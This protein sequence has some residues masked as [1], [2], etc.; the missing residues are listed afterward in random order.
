MNIQEVLESDYEQYPVLLIPSHSS[1]LTPDEE[2]EEKVR[3][4]EYKKEVIEIHNKNKEKVDFLLSLE[5]PSSSSSP[6][7]SS[8]RSLSSSYGKKERR[9]RSGARQRRERR[10]KEKDDEEIVRE[11]REK[12][13]LTFLKDINSE[14]RKQNDSLFLNSPQKNLQKKTIQDLNTALKYNWRIFDTQ[15]NRNI[16]NFYMDIFEKV[17][18]YPQDIILF[19]GIKMSSEPTK[20]KRIYEYGFSSKSYFYEVARHYSPECCIFAIRYPRGHKLIMPIV[21]QKRSVCEFMSLPGELI[22]IDEV[23]D[24]VIYAHFCEYAFPP[25]SQ[26]V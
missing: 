23:G 19:R 17:D 16:Y 1:P 25:F 11:R 6:S 9:E 2:K 20:G 12:P 26:K 7:L 24:D 13:F 18:P 4:E 3:E 5:S 10:E 22:E 21:E 8:S 15:E 14:W